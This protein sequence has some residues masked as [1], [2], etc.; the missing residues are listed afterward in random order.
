MQTIKLYDYNPSMGKLIDV[1]HPL[2]YLKEHNNYATY[3]YADK[4]IM[5]HRKFLNQNDTY[6]I[7]C[8]KGHL[9]KKVVHML[10]YY[11]YNVVQVIK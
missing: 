10:S 5:N 3:I 2:D 11:G 6:Y 8:S 7:M 9:S 1:S 4:L